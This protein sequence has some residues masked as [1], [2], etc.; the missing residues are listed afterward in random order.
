MARGSGAGLELSVYRMTVTVL[1]L[2]AG[3]DSCD[4]VGLA[5]DAYTTGDLCDG[6]VSGHGSAAAGA[7]I[8]STSAG[9]LA[10]PGAQS[11][12]S[13]HVR[14][15]QP[16]AGWAA[17]ES[18]IGL[19]GPPPARP[20]TAWPRPP[21]ILAL[22]AWL[23]VDGIW[24]SIGGPKH[25]GIAR[26]VG[27]DDRRRPR[28]RTGSGGCAWT[29]SSAPCPGCAPPHPQSGQGCPDPLG[30]GPAPH[31]ARAGPGAAAGGRSVW[32]R[33]PRKNGATS[34]IGGG[35]H[36]GTGSKAA[37]TQ[38][39]K[40]SVAFA[41]GG[42][43]PTGPPGAWSIRHWCRVWD[44]GVLVRRSSM[45][46]WRP[47]SPWAGSPN[48][49]TTRHRAEATCSPLRARLA[50]VPVGHLSGVLPGWGFSALQGP[51]LHHV[52]VRDPQPCGLR[53]VRLCVE[54]GLAAD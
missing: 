48:C 49:A 46:P 5:P 22:L 53:D 4:F 6:V 2:R 43:I 34:S 38:V 52:G 11:A 7:G 44:P 40:A 19:R 17:C 12:G 9:M 39:L 47:S 26:G 13:G 28:L 18:G 1:M 32:R 27:P 30:P 29:G 31:P 41:R 33:S 25:P 16:A 3:A 20:V 50:E 8:A 15:C 21:R 54:G 14:R 10:Q 42:C 51:A 45:C 36:P 37:T 24:L 35:T 23:E